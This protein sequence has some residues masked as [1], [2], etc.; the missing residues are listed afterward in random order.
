[1]SHD[2][3]MLPQPVVRPNLVVGSLRDGALTAATCSCMGFCAC[4]ADSDED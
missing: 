2:Q 1:M 3:P 4:F